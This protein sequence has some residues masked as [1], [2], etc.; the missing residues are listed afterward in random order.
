MNKKFIMVLVVF[1]GLLLYNPFFSF[2][3]PNP[4]LRPFMNQE[5]KNKDNE[6]L[7]DFSYFFPG[8]SRDVVLERYPDLRNESTLDYQG[9]KL[10]LYSRTCSYSGRVD[11]EIIKTFP[12]VTQKFVFYDDI[13]VLQKN[14]TIYDAFADILLDWTEKD[15]ELVVTANND[16]EDHIIF[17]SHNHTN[18]SS[19]LLIIPKE[20]VDKSIIEV[21]Y[22]PFFFLK[23]NIKYMECLD[24]INKKDKDFSSILLFLFSICNDELNDANIV[25]IVSSDW[26]LNT[27]L[28]TKT[29]P[30]FK[31]DEDFQTV[32]KQVES[33][34]G[35]TLKQDNENP[36][37]WEWKHWLYEEYY[38][39][40]DGK[41]KIEG[42]C[43]NK[44]TL[45]QTLLD[46][47]ARYGGKVVR[48]GNSFIRYPDTMPDRMIIITHNEPIG[49]T[50]VLFLPR[51]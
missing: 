42:F 11:S 18:A 33:T 44:V 19:V 48:E 38:V 29:M 5:L 32:K 13:L 43:F 16:E 10:E 12:P 31:L 39:F 47:T 17:Q 41:L 30:G 14:E 36:N 2:A 45:S 25:E 28:Y 24:L 34:N 35:I 27:L 6:L 40:K 4:A 26:I 46:L 8:T 50:A 15:C 49:W 37:I 9:K 22:D 1:I 51:L 21:I 7:F 20:K 23:L 3:L